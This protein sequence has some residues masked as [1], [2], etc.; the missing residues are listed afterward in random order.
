M[1]GEPFNEM[2]LGVS[3]KYEAAFAAIRSGQI[4]KA[5]EAELADYARALA[6][7]HVS[8]AGQDQVAAVMLI[9][10][11]Q[12]AHS[13]KRAERQARLIIGLT[14]GLLILTVVLLV[15]TAFLY[16]DARQHKAERPN[17]AMQRT[18][19]RSYA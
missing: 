8:H 16:Q 14:V 9:H 2:N 19:D 1:S 7:Y 18:A 6:S 11:L 13:S 5:N 15:Y 12:L 4:L 17:Q 3:E 10:S